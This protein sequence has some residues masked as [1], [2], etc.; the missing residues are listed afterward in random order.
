MKLK[1][2]WTFFLTLAMIFTIVPSAFAED[3]TGTGEEDNP[4]IISTSEQ[5]MALSEILN[6]GMPASN[7]AAPSEVAEAYQIF[8][9]DENFKDGFSSLQSGYFKL[10]NDID[11]SDE[12]TFS[13][14]G[15]FKGTFDGNGNSIK[16]SINVTD[17][18]ESGSVQIGLFKDI[19]S[20][21]IK[22]LTIA[23]GSSIS[24]TSSGKAILYVGSIYGGNNSNNERN[25]I[26]NCTNYAD[27][28]V[29]RAVEGASNY[30]GGFAG[31]AWGDF[32]YCVNYGNIDVNSVNYCGVAG[33]AGFINA[34]QNDRTCSITNSENHGNIKVYRGSIDS[35]VKQGEIRIAGLTAWSYYDF[36]IENCKN[37]GS[38]E[39]EG[40]DLTAFA[41]FSAG[42][43]L[44]KKDLANYGSI[45]CNDKPLPLATFEENKDNNVL[46]YIKL[47]G[48]P[49]EK[50]IYSKDP[51]NPIVL[52]ENGEGWLNPNIQFIGSSNYNGTYY[53][54]FENSGTSLYL[55]HVKDTS[56]VVY[57]LKNQI[58]ADD[59][60]DH[61]VNLQNHTF[62]IDSLE[63]L[64][65]L[66][67]ALSADVKTDD[68]AKM[69]LQNLWLT[70]IFQRII[71][72]LNHSSY[73]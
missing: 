53:V 43:N 20:A 44:V 34:K 3:L 31:Y 9:I 60:F 70:V 65:L 45:I 55:G 16:Y 21:T 10:A 5:F 67:N 4:Y 57:G 46:F 63:K 51:E 32:D 35:S 27:I 13:G 15:L 39:A 61:V 29:N 11:L 62:N 2:I 22:N 41:P 48:Q 58:N 6:S 23:E 33:I 50:V 8:G 14:A 40:L 66:Q 49:G 59:E 37:Y 19:S 56:G 69:L 17:G 68:T 36:T 42:S 1:K 72:L 24:V 47:K 7:D 12:S 26:I 54:T 18:T 73:Y 52:D 71:I 64:L 30:A 28:T 25:S 38:I